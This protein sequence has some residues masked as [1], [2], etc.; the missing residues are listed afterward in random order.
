MQDRPSDVDVSIDKEAFFH[1]VEKPEASNVGENAMTTLAQRVN[2]AGVLPL[3]PGHPLADSSGLRDFRAALLAW[4]DESKRDLPWRG[5]PSLYKTVVS[6][7]ML[8]QTRVSTVLPYFERWLKSFPDFATLAAAPEEAVLKAW[9]G[10]G[11]YSRARNLRRLA[12]ELVALPEVPEEPAAWERFPGVGPY[13]AAAVTSIT[14]GAPAAVADGNVVRVLTRLL[15]HDE[16]FRD[17][18]TAQ[19]KLRPLAQTL[20]SP[21]RPGDYNQAVMELGATVCHRRSP[22]CAV[23]PVL[24]FCRAGSRGDAEAF[25]VLAKRKT[26]R[27]TTRRL[28]ITR[29]GALL[30]HETPADSK[31]LSG[32]LELPRPED[33]PED[34]RPRLDRTSHLVT[35]RRAIANQNIEEPIHRANLPP[36]AELPPDCTLRFV[37]FDELPEVTLSGPHRKWVEE[38]LAAN[39]EDK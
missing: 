32:L 1:K 27:V 13:V 12:A 5:S 15:T 11:Y 21:E 36:N 7:F 35:K 29:G 17:G 23:C 34:L 30:L 28:W 31:R 18:A 14:F 37:P 39:G 22:L 2:T 10:L 3:P 26:E 20:L 25:P 24:S 6:E 4:Y 19:R 33:L 8:Q 9:E 38:L 16:E